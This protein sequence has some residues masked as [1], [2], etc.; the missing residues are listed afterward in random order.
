MGQYFAL[1]FQLPSMFL[2]EPSSWVGYRLRDGIRVQVEA[3][4]PISH[5]GNSQRTHLAFF[6]GIYTRLNGWGL[7]P[8]RAL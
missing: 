8:F 4:R 1:D 3:D 6:L 5:R 2:P 7:C